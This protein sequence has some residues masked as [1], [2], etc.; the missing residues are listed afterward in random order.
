MDFT[1][2]T[3]A[4][5]TTYVETLNTG[6]QQKLLT[7]LERKVLMDEAK[8]L[9]KSVKKNSVSIQEICDII[10]DVRRKKSSK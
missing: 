1:T 7:A 4:K 8:R 5:I 2:N 9:N 3:V 10:N 6:D